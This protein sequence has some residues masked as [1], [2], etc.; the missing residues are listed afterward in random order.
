MQPAGRSL[1]TPDITTQFQNLCHYIELSR[2]FLQFHIYLIFVIWLLFF[3]IF[4]RILVSL[5]LP[6]HVSLAD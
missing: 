3:P 4:K 5:V 6:P 1:L 2:F